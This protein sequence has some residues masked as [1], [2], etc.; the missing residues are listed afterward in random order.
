MCNDPQ[1]IV[2]CKTRGIVINS[3]HEIQNLVETLYKYSKFC[4]CSI[5]EYRLFTYSYENL[6]FT[7]IRRYISLKE[8]SWIFF[9]CKNAF[10]F[11]FCGSRHLKVQYIN[12]YNLSGFKSHKK[13]QKPL[14][15]QR[16][17]FN[18]SSLRKL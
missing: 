13:F 11:S 18:W 1:R 2:R 5:S 15:P 6:I 17:H 16:K 9:L 8:N 3:E 14:K 7:E 10:W 12:K 4:L